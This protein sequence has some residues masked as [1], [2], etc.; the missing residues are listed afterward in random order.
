MVCERLTRPKRRK[1]TI[2]SSRPLNCTTLTPNMFKA[3]TYDTQ[4][5]V[6]GSPGHDPTFWSTAARIYETPETWYRPSDQVGRLDLRKHL[7]VCSAAPSCHHA[8]LKV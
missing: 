5:Y 4:I 6:P 2:Q 1:F 8:T 7:E 3:N